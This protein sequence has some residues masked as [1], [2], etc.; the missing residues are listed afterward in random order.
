MTARAMVA[1]ATRTM[2]ATVTTAAT[3][4]TAAAMTPN[5]NEDNEDGNG[6]NY[7]KSN[8]NSNINNRLGGERCQ[9]RRDNCGG[10]RS[11]PPRDAAIALTGCLV[12]TRSRRIMLSFP[13]DREEYSLYYAWEYMENLDET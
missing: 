8:D 11:R 5:G 3:A 9:S 4:A 6:K 10:G 1:G 12:G 7:D 2:A 13:G